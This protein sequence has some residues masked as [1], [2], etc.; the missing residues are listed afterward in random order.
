MLFGKTARLTAVDGINKAGIPVMIIH[1]NQ[2]ESIKYDGASI[3]S[4]Q[5]EI[6]NPKAVFLTNSTEGHNGHNS[7][8]VSEASI[9]YADG[10][11]KEYKKL[12]DQYSGKIPDDVRAEYYKGVDKFLAN[13]LD[14]DFMGQINLFFE[15]ALE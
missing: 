11:N 5:K 4:R 1:G 2:D 6:T 10:K 15:A 13:Q 14:P 9:E 8:N 3:I 12:Y 7:L